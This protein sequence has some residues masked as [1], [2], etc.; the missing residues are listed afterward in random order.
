[1]LELRRRAYLDLVAHCLDGLPDEACGLL[2]GDPAG[3]RAERFHP[4]GNDAASSR[5]Y[6]VNPR[7][8]LRADRAAE[9]AGHEIIGVVHSHT[10]TPPYPSP[11]DVAQAPDPSWHYA[12]VSLAGGAPSLRSYRIVE[13]NISEEDVVLLD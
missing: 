7:D 4:C 5:V 1:M 8:H 10:H 3:A 12:I 2:S 11:T 9:E 6:T 13:G